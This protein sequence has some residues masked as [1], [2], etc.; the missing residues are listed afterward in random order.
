ML[1]LPTVSFAYKLDDCFKRALV[2][3]EALQV[4][5]EA[6]I[7][8]EARG[9]QA[10]AAYYPTLSLQS[11]YLRQD[12]I[13]SPLAANISPDEQRVSKAKLSQNLFRGFR[14][15]STVEQKNYERLSAEAARAETME[16]VYLDVARSFYDVLTYR[17]EVGDID[18]ELDALG[19]RRQELAS[20]K[21]VG[22]AR[23]TDLLSIEVST[24]TLESEKALIQGQ[25]LIA[26]E[27]LAFLSGIERD[28]PLEDRDSVPETLA[29]L[30]SWLTR[31]DSRSDIKEA[32]AA[33]GAAEVGT[34]TIRSEYYPTVDLDGNYYIERPG[35]Y[36]DSKWD[37]LL[38]VNL[39]LFSGGSTQKKLN[40]NVSL[41]RSRDL[42]IQQ[43]SRQAKLEIQ[44]AYRLIEAEFKQLK[45]LQRAEQLAHDQYEATRSDNKLGLVT[46]IELLQILANYYKVRRGISQ[47]QYNIKYDYR[48]LQLKAAQTVLDPALQSQAARP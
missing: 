24:A 15:S 37:V 31:V 30:D 19:R 6:L 27:K 46:N 11:T 28:A 4:K 45:K 10:S 8:A 17:A 14:D 25:I 20:L 35:L 18:K 21:R 3:S 7:Q 26:Q 43:L 41:S 47:V 29:P 34:R 16:Q 13:E 42:Q 5:D 39:P 23:D 22:R 2:K 48:R 36:K 44:S 1:V 12:P 9:Q 33:L 38:S 40:E 32:R